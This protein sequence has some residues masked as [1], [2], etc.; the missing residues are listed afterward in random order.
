[1]RRRA[2]FTLIELLVV[3]AIIAILAAILFPVFAKARENARKSNCLSNL[4]QITQGSLMYVQDYDE[5]FFG[6]TQGS[7][8]TFYPQTGPYLDWTLQILP[9]T[10]NTAI[11]LCPSNRAANYLGQVT[12]TVVRDTSHG[13]GMN[14]W[15][16]YYYYYIS[17]ANINT[18]AD[19]IWFTDC[20][21]YLVYSMYYTLLDPANA[22][23]G[24]NGSARLRLRHND[25][26][27]VAFVDG[28]VKW[29]NKQ[30]IE[31]DTG[32]TTASKYWWGR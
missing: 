31:A 7:R 20:D 10:K 1:M 9:Y 6:H 32:N 22:T 4:K 5:T 16:V 15:M 27:N 13:Y 24:T 25:G 11:F 28:H 17:L 12:P 8:A 26:V 18:P 2:G 14:Y 21:N 3:I 29:F 23:Y 19:T 30:T